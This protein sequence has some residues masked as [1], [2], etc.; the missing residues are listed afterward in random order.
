MIDSYLRSSSDLDDHAVHLLFSANRWELASR[1]ESLVA[2]GTTVILDRYVYSGIVFTAAKGL[3][4][5][6]CR[7]P[8]VGLPRPDKVVFLDLDLSE[9]SARGGWG[10]ERYEVE[11]M[12]LKVAW[13]F[14]DFGANERDKGDWRVVHAHK[15]VEE[16]REDV[17]EVAKEALAFAGSN[18]LRRV[19]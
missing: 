12:Q 2:G 8:E 10:K 18:D 9:A 13:L 15:S 3:D 1:I 14:R 6:Y 17:W 4:V 11:E 16:V 19:L 5:E 7:A